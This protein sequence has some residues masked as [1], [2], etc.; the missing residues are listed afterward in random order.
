MESFFKIFKKLKAIEQ[1]FTLPKD[2]RNEIKEKRKLRREFKTT[3]D[4]NTKKQLNKINTSIQN[5]TV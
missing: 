2:I 5:K 3:R 4:K 1:N